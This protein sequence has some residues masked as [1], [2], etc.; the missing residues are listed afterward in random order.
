MKPKSNIRLL[1]NTLIYFVAYGGTLAISFILTPYLIGRFGKETYSFYTIATNLSSYMMTVCN[2]LNI[3]ACRYIAVE[4]NKDQYQKANDYFKS[5]FVANIIICLV[6]TVPMALIVVFLER[7]MDVPA[8]GAVDIK[9][10]FTF[11]FAS[12]I[13][14]VMASLFSICT[15]ARDRI[16]LRAYREVAAGV[17]KLILIFGGFL[18][19]TSGIWWIGATLLF[20]ALFNGVIQ[21]CY[22]RYL[23][24]ELKLRKGTFR[25]GYVKEIALSSLWNTL[26]ALG[27]NLLSGIAII[28]FNILISAEA[29]SYLSIVHT[30]VGLLNGVITVVV[31]AFYP[32]MLQSF[33]KSQ[34]GLLETT[35]NLQKVLSTVTNVAVLGVL[36]MCDEFYNLWLPG[37]ETDVLRTITAIQ[38]ISI[39]FTG[40]IYLYTNVNTLTLNIKRPAVFLGIAAVLNMIGMWIMTTV[41]HASMYTTLLFNVLV[42][43][44]YYLIF[45]P[46]IL[47]EKVPVKLSELY[48]S[49]GFS[50]VAAVISLIPAG[51]VDQAWETTGWLSFFAKVFCVGI[52]LLACNGGILLIGKIRLSRKESKK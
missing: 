6:I 2:A 22:T 44:S 52:I 46:I 9:W 40:N 43:A 23:T 26:N 30:P 29:S 8:A 27:G 19:F 41:F 33:A 45:L 39:F 48:G 21:F 14:N 16:D 4:L 20:L 15:V 37:G 11:V 25:G 1:Y 7:L 18:F 17:L 32:R 5:V 13:V 28:M 35:K 31:T 50:V 3:M 42:N 36:L 10:L 51:L 49:F 38:L 34:E 12:L 24:P 47:K